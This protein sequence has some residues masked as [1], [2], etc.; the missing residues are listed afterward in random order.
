M[1]EKIVHVCKGCADIEFET[2]H[3]VKLKERQKSI[4]GNTISEVCKGC[5]INFGA[6]PPGDFDCSDGELE[7]E[8][9]CEDLFN[10]IWREIR[11]ACGVQFRKRWRFN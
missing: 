9:G 6:R 4:D 8:Q 3:P 10:V 5:V 11:I 2:F 7:V 1:Y